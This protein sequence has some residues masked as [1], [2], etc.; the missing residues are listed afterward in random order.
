MVTGGR[1]TALA[2]LGLIV[3]AVIPTAVR[4]AGGPDRAREALARHAQVVVLGR[5]TAIRSN[6]NAAGTLISTYAT[7]D[8]EE[9]VVG[10]ARGEQLMVKALGGT[11]G[12]ISQMVVD[13]PRFELGARDVLFL[14]AADEPDAL[15]TVGLGRGQWRVAADPRSAEDLVI[16]ASGPPR[17]LPDGAPVAEDGGPAERLGAVLEDLRG[18]R[19]TA[20]GGR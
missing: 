19:H 14:V 6:W 16:G 15:R 18:Y 11:V 7:Y 12:H 8:V 10:A 2:A 17:G 1:H 4:A 20:A 13:G 3:A 5:C 9:A